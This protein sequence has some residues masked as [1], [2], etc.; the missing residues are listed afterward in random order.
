MSVPL[1]PFLSVGAV[2]ALFVGHA[3]LDAYLALF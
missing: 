3:I 1:V 2:V